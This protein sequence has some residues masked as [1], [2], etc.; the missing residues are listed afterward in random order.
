MRASIEI[1]TPEIAQIYLAHSEGNRSMRREKISSYARD[2]SAGNWT[3]N[4]E[5][6]IFSLT[7]VLLDGHHR[8]NAVV[9]SGS[10]IQT[11]VVRGVPQESAKTIDMGASRTAADA[12]S[13]YGMKNPNVLQAT[14]RVLMSATRGFPRSA[15]PSTQEIFKFVD[16]N[17]GIQRAASFASQKHFPKIG[18]LLGAIYFA[19]SLKGD[20]SRAEAFAEVFRSGIPGYIGCPAHSLRERIQRESARGKHMQPAELHRLVFSAWEKFRNGDQVKKLKPTSGFALDGW[21]E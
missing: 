16:E 7:G 20:V 3:A 2:M 15:R 1:V 6:I 13:F 8:L 18:P 14:V 4:G 5:P 12:L 10:S 21:S 19:E 17:E 11:L 9:K